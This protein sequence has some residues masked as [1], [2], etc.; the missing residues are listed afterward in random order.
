MEEI[1]KNTE[2]EETLLNI[3]F[4]LPILM[5]IMFILFILTFVLFAIM[6]YSPYYYGDTIMF[7]VIAVIMAGLY[8]A[9]CLGVRSNECVVTNKV[10][11]GRQFVIFGYKKFSYRLD[12]ISDITSSNILGISSIKI[13]FNQG[14]V[15]VN[16]KNKPFIIAYVSQYSQVIEK[17]N[18]IL[19]SVRNDKD[20]QVSLSLKQ[21]EALNNIASSIGNQ[22]NENPQNIYTLDSIKQLKNLLDEGLISQEEYEK[23]KK[24]LLERL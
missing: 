12:S 24:D 21:T 8:I 19:E 16:G 23:K 18:R 14:Y 7:A 1:R 4:Q 6:L 3:K 2:R 9:S 11:K 10:I 17:L 15:N 13:T 22:K 20:V 5:H